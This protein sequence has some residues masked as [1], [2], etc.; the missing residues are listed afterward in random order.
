M[1]G[2]VGRWAGGLG[3]RWECELVGGLVGR[4]VDVWIR[5]WGIDG[6]VGGWL[7]G[8]DRYEGR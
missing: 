8:V 7:A 2:L 5:R 3:G 1:G 4:W 6:K